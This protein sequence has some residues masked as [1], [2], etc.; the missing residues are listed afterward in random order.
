MVDWGEKNEMKSKAYTSPCLI[1]GTRW[2]REEE[3]DE[4]IFFNTLYDHL[5][6]IHVYY[7]DYTN[8]IIGY[9]LHMNSIFNYH[10][11]G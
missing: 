5:Y 6:I 7:L 10:I 3:K 4:F 2:E 9:Y 1:K 8:H 11:I